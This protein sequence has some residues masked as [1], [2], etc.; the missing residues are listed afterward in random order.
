MT[1]AIS[2][3]V[4]LMKFLTQYLRYCAV[5]KM[6]PLLYSHIYLIFDLNKSS[7]NKYESINRKND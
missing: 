2:K 3:E 1:N 6:S 7:I 5:K 4:N